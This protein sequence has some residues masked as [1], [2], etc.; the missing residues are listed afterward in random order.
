MSRCK[1]TIISF[2]LILSFTISPLSFVIAAEGSNRYHKQ[3]SPETM[4]VDLVLCRPLGFV[5]MLGGTVFFV[6]SSP[7]SAL[8]GNIDQAWDSLVVIPA[9]YT[10]SR[11][12][13]QFD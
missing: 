11:P 6:L 12:L 7:F 5:A 2:F 13:G 3:P 1:K 4:T 10:F 9:N 8:G